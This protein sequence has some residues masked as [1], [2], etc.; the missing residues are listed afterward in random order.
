M[1]PEL[2]Q[3]VFEVNKLCQGLKEMLKIPRYRARLSSLT[4]DELGRLEWVLEESDKLEE[5][6]KEVPQ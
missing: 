5:L 4:G 3:R 2:L 6:I 1:G